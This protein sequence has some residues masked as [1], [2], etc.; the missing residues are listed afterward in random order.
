MDLEIISYVTPSFSFF[1]ELPLDFSAVN[2]SVK[3]Y[4]ESFTGMMFNLQN[5]QQ[6]F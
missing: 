5:Y 1:N 4:R 3:F 6:T 2:A